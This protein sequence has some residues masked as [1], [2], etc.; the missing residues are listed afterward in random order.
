MIM[1]IRPAS[2]SNLNTVLEQM[3]E[4]FTDEEQGQIVAIIGEVLGR[5]DGEAERH[6]MTENAKEARQEEYN[7]V[8]QQEEVMDVENR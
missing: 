3:E 7:Q 2:E 8:S 5:P 6:A 4:R 1:N